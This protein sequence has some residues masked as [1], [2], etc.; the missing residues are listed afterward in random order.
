MWLCV[1]Y[2]TQ[3]EAPRPIYT[4][5]WRCECRWA[6]A[7]TEENFCAPPLGTSARN[8]RPLTSKSGW[9]RKDSP[10]GRLYMK[11]DQLKFDETTNITAMYDSKTIWWCSLAVRYL[12]VSGLPGRS[13]YLTI[14]FCYEYKNEHTSRSEMKIDC[15]LWGARNRKP[16]AARGRTKWLSAGCPCLLCVHPLSLRFLHLWS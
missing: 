13:A 3:S 10:I 2:C 9:A 4:M 5:N 16:Y 14:I 7:A 8:H 12:C 15:A 1:F 11:S 6:R